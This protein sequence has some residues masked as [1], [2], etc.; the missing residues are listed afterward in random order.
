MPFRW[1]RDRGR[2]GGR[3]LI[4]GRYVVEQSGLVA[5]ATV[6]P[7]QRSRHCQIHKDGIRDQKPHRVRRW[8]DPDKSPIPFGTF[9]AVGSIA[10]AVAATTTTA[11]AEFRRQPL[12]QCRSW[13]TTLG[14][15]GWDCGTGR[16]PTHGW[17]QD[18]TVCEIFEQGGGSVPHGFGGGVVFVSLGGPGGTV[19]VQSQIQDTG[20]FP[21]GRRRIAGMGDTGGDGRRVRAEEGRIVSSPPRTPKEPPARARGAQA[22]PR[23]VMLINW[24]RQR[25]I[26]E[27]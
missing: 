26:A 15:V 17:G 12:L 2:G 19:C 14:R 10:A 4:R 7:S 23:K 11:K 6:Y 21:N 24:C 8:S 1:G 18:G 5:T 9:A 22:R 20:V 13:P 27:R 16:L 3:R 25:R